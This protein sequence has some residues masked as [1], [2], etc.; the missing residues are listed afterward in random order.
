M[1]AYKRNKNLY[2][3]VLIKIV[4]YCKL[5]N[6]DTINDCIDINAYYS[7]LASARREPYYIVD[8]NSE[9]KDISVNDFKNKDVNIDNFKLLDNS[10]LGFNV[11][12]NSISN[13]NKILKS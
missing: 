1:N 10:L 3:S 7:I 2:I 5:N 6:Y 11:K 8:S 12:L 13:N 4:I 9:D